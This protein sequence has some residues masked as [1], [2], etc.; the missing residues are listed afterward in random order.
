MERQA[1]EM[2]GLFE[3]CA[4]PRRLHGWQDLLQA[5]LHRR[6]D[7][8]TQAL[9]CC[10]GKVFSSQALLERRGCALPQ[11]QDLL[12]TALQR[13]DRHRLRHTHPEGPGRLTSSHHLR[14]SLGPGSCHDLGATLKRRGGKSSIQAQAEAVCAQSGLRPPYSSDRREEEEGAWAN[15]SHRELARGCANKA[16]QAETL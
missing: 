11:P 5:S 3:D 2:A 12:P 4:C 16:G 6:T 13:E 8:I 9:A 15:C 10:S 7:A 1:A 14:P